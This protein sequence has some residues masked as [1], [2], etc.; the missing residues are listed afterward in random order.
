M[1]TENLLSYAMALPEHV[2]EL[3][4]I[5]AGSANDDIIVRLINGFSEYAQQECNRSFLKADGII[6]YHNGGRRYFNIEAPPIR[7]DVITKVGFQLFEDSGRTF[8]AADEL[9]LWD[10]YEVDVKSG[11]VKLIC[12]TFINAPMALKA[13]YNGGLVKCID[14]GATFECPADL[15]QACAMQV[16]FIFKNRDQLGTVA[17]DTPSGSMIRLFTPTQ[18][19]PQVKATLERYRRHDI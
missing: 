3:L 5:K 6:E 1:T 16:A 2:R 17:L 7:L 8:S 10:H 18:L 14:N 19:L 13:V 9:D 11:L 15:N 12:G 4:N